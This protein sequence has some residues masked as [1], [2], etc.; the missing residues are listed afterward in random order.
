VNH[1]KIID[2]VMEKIAPKQPPKGWWDIMQDKIKKENPEYTSDVLDKVVGDIWYN[3]MDSDKKKDLMDKFESK[4]SSIIARIYKDSGVDAGAVHVKN[5]DEKKSL[6]II[7][8]EGI[9][10]LHI[11]D[12]DKGKEKTIFMDV[13]YIKEV[14]ELLL[15]SDID[16][17]RSH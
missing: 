15:E 2:K 1:K 8:N 16:T 17:K 7:K 6:D 3:K 10:V 4:T 11:E 5:K 13:K 9:K 12:S 14:S